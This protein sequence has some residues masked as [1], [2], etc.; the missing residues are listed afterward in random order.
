MEG[1]QKIE[2]PAPMCAL[3]PGTRLQEYVIRSVIGEGGFGIP[4]SAFASAELPA[5]LLKVIEAGLSVEPWLR[6]QSVEAFITA[7]EREAM[8]KGCVLKE[9]DIILIGVYVLQAHY[10]EGEEPE[11]A[12]AAADKRLMVFELFSHIKNLITHSDML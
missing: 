7:L 6:P 9:E 5:R 8:K 11:Q 4:L 10:M 1:A 3:P 12:P 2:L